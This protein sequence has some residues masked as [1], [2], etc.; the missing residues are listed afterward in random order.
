MSTE[1][2]NRSYLSGVRLSLHEGKTKQ[3]QEL[4]PVFDPCSSK[5]DLQSS[6]SVPWELCERRTRARTRTNRTESAFD[7]TGT[8]VRVWGAHGH[9]TS[10][11]EARVLCDR[12][13]C[14]WMTHASSSLWC[15]VSVPFTSLY[16]FLL[17]DFLYYL[18]SKHWTYPQF[19][20]FPSAILTDFS[21]PGKIFHASAFNPPHGKITGTLESG[22]G[23]EL[24]KEHYINVGCH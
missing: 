23:L 3:H 4:P 10:K 22:F 5:Q 12:G 1:Y 19:L 18:P 9:S 7:R 20:P 24:W 15:L 11:A 16:Q 6:I 17:S 8:R 21:V 2:R 13:P 14:P